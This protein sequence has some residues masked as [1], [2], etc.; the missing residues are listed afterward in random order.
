MVRVIMGLQGHGKTKQIIE[1]TNKAAAEDL[2]VVCIERGTKLTYDISHKARLVDVSAYF[3]ESYE[4]LKAFICGLHSANFDISKIFIDSL[5]KVSK[6]DCE[7]ETEDFLLWAEKFG[8]ENKIDFVITI[9]ADDA[10][11]SDTIKKFF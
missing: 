10:K 2:A 1:L 6:S 11:A 8:E 9:S 7:K 3:I 4:H 5:Y